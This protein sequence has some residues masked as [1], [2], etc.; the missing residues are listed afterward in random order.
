MDLEQLLPIVSQVTLVCLVGAVGLRARWKDV[1]TTFDEWPRLWRAVVVVNLIV[2]AVAL[3]MC[4]LLPIEK[5]VRI[6]IM[7]IAVSPLAPLLTGKVMRAGMDASRTVGLYVMLILVAVPIVPATVALLSD[8]LPPDASVSVGAIARL[9]LISVLA[10]LAVG[11][12][13]AQVWPA[14]ANR[15]A[16]PITIAGYGILAL[17][18]VP[19]IWTQASQIGSLVGNGTI[20]A[21]AVTIVAGIVAGHLMGGPQPQGRS[22][23]ALAAATRNPGIAGLIASSSFPED[24]QLQLVIMLFVAVSVICSAAYLRW[25]KRSQAEGRGEAD[26]GHA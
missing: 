9:V 22:A 17:L 4:L 13:V 23:L 12:G 8:L 10:P 20:I 24:R 15:L 11:M 14:V 3:A 21:M 2:P 1:I 26:A 18:A 5:S 25:Q 19:V 7:I 16:G 6:G